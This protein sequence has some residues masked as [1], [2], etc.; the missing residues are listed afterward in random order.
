MEEIVSLRYGRSEDDYGDRV[1]KSQKAMLKS[2][3]DT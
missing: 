3:V 2:K 1:W